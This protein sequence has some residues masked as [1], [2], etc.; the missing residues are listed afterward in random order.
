MQFRA[1][2]EKFLASGK[3]FV[4]FYVTESLYYSKRFYSIG[5]AAGW[6]NN[7]V[8]ELDGAGEWTI[9]EL[10]ILDGDEMQRH[11]GKGI[12]YLGAGC[13]I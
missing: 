10:D 3:F 5:E 6:I 2:S 12:C 4:T 13:L 1:L 11:S 8:V 7:H 9:R